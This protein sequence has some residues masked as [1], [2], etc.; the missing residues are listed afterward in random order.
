MSERK[1][2]RLSEA[3]NTVIQTLGLLRLYFNYNLRIR[4]QPQKLSNRLID[5]CEEPCTW[6][7]VY[8]SDDM[9][10]GILHLLTQ[11]RLDEVLARYDVR[12]GVLDGR[13]DS[14]CLINS[15]HITCLLHELHKLES[16]TRFNSRMTIYGDTKTYKP[17]NS[18]LSSTQLR[19]LSDK[20]SKISSF[21]LELHS[22]SERGRQEI[23]F[24]RQIFRYTHNSAKGIYQ[25]SSLHEP[26]CPRI[27]VKD[28]DN[29]YPKFIYVENAEIDL[30]QA[31]K[32]ESANYEVDAIITWVN[33][34]D[35]KWEEQWINRFGNPSSITKPD[36]VADTNH[37]FHIKQDSDRFSSSDELLYCL[38]SINSYLSWIR[39][40]YIVSNCSPPKWLDLENGRISWIDHSEIMK[41]EALPTFNSHAIESCLHKIKG[42][43]EHFIY[44][45]DDFVLLKPTSRASFFDPLGRPL[46]NAENYAII[47]NSYLNIV[48]KDYSIAAVNSMNALLSKGIRLPSALNLHAHVPY[49]HR[50]SILIELEDLLT[51]EFR[52][53][54]SSPLRSETDINVMSF[55]AHWYGYSQGKYIFNPLSS[56]RD[57]IIVKPSNIDDLIQK[58]ISPRFACFNDGDGT[59]KLGKYKKI[60]SYYLD[61]RL[62]SQSIA[63]A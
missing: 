22:L 49:A 16:S 10:K 20:L 42:L 45:N 21:Y 47:R 17:L 15:K 44:F 30:L 39:N 50:K 63:E 23:I 4:R 53:T 14:T 35:P 57:Y 5:G 36:T 19:A 18:K 26:I 1:N 3:L 13:S 32:D 25:L 56:P 46:I 37:K 12:T 6:P 9:N 8:G 58:K 7:S 11:Q 31:N 55:A 2:V 43:S 62:A 60:V 29:L 61:Y 51:N 33:N 59:S 24:A 27:D 38:R 41:E 54:E 28:F 34:K 48:S 52:Q 40:I